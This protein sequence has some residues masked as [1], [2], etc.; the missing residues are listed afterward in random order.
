MPP[1]R[2]PATIAKLIEKNLELPT[3]PNVA[4]RALKELA[5]ANTNAQALGRIIEQDQ[6]VTG[7]I[8]KISNSAMYRRGRKTTNVQ[9]A[10]MVL[11][12]ANLKT[13]VITASS[14]MIYKRF[15]KLEEEMWNHSVACA[16]AA[17]LIARSRAPKLRDEAFVAGLMHDVGKVVMNNGD[18]EKF[19][20]SVVQAQQSETRSFEAEQEI[21]GFSH[22]DVGAL[23]VRRWELSESL[24]QAL[25]FHHEPELADA[26]AEGAA[27]LVHLTH[28]A[29]E[30]VHA[31]GLGTVDGKK[32]ETDIASLDSA[33]RFNIDEENAEGILKEISDTYAAERSAF[34]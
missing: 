29:N 18:R 25:L 12:F 28:L 14:R 17:H 11:G 8:L 31:L 1:A 3:I 6:G 15:G 27:D 4:A 33:A 23:L 19:L 2:K 9:Q 21:F 5:D 13:L 16:L 34:D 7:R 24:E 22:V 10:T 30:I 26:L 20:Q 32:R